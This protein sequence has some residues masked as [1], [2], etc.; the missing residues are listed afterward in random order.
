[1]YAMKCSLGQHFS[2]GS[3][4]PL[5]SV[6]LNPAASV[7]N[8]AQGVFEGLKAQRSD[9]GR[10][11]LFRP[12]ENARRMKMGAER[13]CMPCPSVEQ[14]VNAVKHTVIA[15]RR[16]VPPPGKGSLYIR[17]L[18]IASG[19]ALGLRPPPEFTF[20]TYASPV[21]SYHKSPLD[22]KVENKLFRAITG[23]GGTGGIKSIA[24]YAPVFRAINEAK[25][26]GFSDVLFLDAATANYIEEVSS[27]NVFVVK[28]NVISTPVADGSILPGIT[29]KSIIE[30]ATDL[31]Y[32]VMERDVEVEETLQ[33]DEVFC[34]GTAMGVKS[35]AS[36]TYNNRRVEYKT[37][38]DSVCQK[39]YDTLVGIQ[40]GLV[41]TT[42]NWIVQVD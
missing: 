24:N 19:V 2:H 27:S 18:L 28:G 5:S 31:G 22:L 36:V 20:L 6:S 10:I 4:T 35:V 8:Y 15:N 38:A 17:P 42:K 30:L 23:H 7:L 26:Q 40:T 9:E 25:I 37:G 29:R 39:L 12:E 41:E 13:M 33:A 14:F 21:N 3:L 34:T 32:Q 1:M 16:W 11:L